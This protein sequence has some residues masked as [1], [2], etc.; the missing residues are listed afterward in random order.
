MSSLLALEGEMRETI[1]VREVRAPDRGQGKHRQRVG[2]A[3]NRTLLRSLNMGTGR[4]DSGEETIM[5]RV[6]CRNCECRQPKG[7]SCRRCSRPL[8]GWVEPPPE[9]A[10]EVVAVKPVQA[11]VIVA[12]DP[13]QT[14]AQIERTVILARVKHFHGNVRRAAQSLGIGRATLYRKVAEYQA[15]SQNGT[16]SSEP[17]CNQNTTMQL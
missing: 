7:P 10:A 6:Q 1:R 3:G 17:S 14:F 5:E 13:S 2:N 8:P 16:K 15:D 4:G 12:E 11:A 9:P